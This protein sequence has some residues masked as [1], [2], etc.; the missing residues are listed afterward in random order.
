MKRPAALA[1]FGLER[2]RF[3]VKGIGDDVTVVA[4]NCGTVQGCLPPVA[5]NKIY[6]IALGGEFVVKAEMAGAPGSSS[7]M[8]TSSQRHASQT[9]PSSSVQDTR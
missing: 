6:F 2:Q 9:L 4:G 8:P 1:A 3:S 7:T 5:G